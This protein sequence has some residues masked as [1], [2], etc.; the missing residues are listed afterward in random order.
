VA[1]LDADP[2]VVEVHPRVKVIDDHGR[3]MEDY[4][5]QI[6]TDSPSLMH[7]FRE[8]VL[9][10]HRRH[11][12]FEIFGLMRRS[13]VQRVPRQGAYSHADR[14]FISRITLMGR[15]KQIPEQLFLARWH[16]TQSMQARPERSNASVVHRLLGPGVLPPP[17]WWNPALKDRVTFPEWNLLREHMR[18]IGL[19]GSSLKD[20]GAAT[21][22]VLEWVLHNWPKL[23][24]DVIFAM[25]T[26][27]ARLMERMR[28]RPEPAI[29]RSR[30]VTN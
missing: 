26:V 7:R 14:V 21:L 28:P 10:K 15:V 9:A 27:T 6:E 30:R 5:F 22:V 11:R 25:D 4:N 16:A 8:I 3:E 19:A 12:N 17:E 2:S 13:A 1:A 24:R 23:V 29:D 18:S 20:R